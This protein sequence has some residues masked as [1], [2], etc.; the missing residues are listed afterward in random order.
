V[1]E[2]I[3]GEEEY[4]LTKIITTFDNGINRIKLQWGEKYS[5]SGAIIF[6]PQSKSDPDTVLFDR[7]ID[8]FT[9]LN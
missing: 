3:Q 8:S 1:T 5:D 7:V 4:G 2:G 9:F 6:Y